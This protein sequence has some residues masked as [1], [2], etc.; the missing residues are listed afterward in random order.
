MSL[1]SGIIN[2]KNANLWPDK[3]NELIA[4]YIDIPFSI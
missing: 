3:L 4:E 1:F 2:I